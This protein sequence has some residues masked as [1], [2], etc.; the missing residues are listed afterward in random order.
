MNTRR[1]ISIITNP[2]IDDT[3][4]TR[5]IEDIP[6]R[7]YMRADHRLAGKTMVSL[8]DLQDETLVMTEDGSL[9]QRTL[10]ETARRNALV[11]R[12][13]IKMTTFAVV[14]E[15]ILHGLGVGLL[16]QD[17]VHPSDRL[18]SLPVEEMQESFSNYFVIPSEKEKLR[19]IR[20]FIELV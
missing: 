3:V 9:T 6:Y 16:L 12:K 13:T 5:K 18:V 10:F 11:F 1:R 7:A 17:S 8:H 20:Q 14:K 19:Q 4:F 2:A 15:A